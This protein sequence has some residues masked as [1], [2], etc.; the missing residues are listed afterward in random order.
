[1]PDYKVISLIG[2]RPQF[3]KAA[4]LSRVLKSKVE[5][6]IVHTGQHY[7]KNMSENFFTDLNIPEPAFNLEVGS[8]SH[9]VQTARIMTE[10][11]IVVKKIR[12]SAVI[13]F[14]DTNSTVAGGLVSAKLHIPLVHVEAGL[15]SW[16]RE[17]PEEHNR[18]VTDHL[19]DLC[20]APSRTAIKN[21]KKEGLKKRSVWSGDIMF[22]ALLYNRERALESNYSLPDEPYHLLTLH[23]PS[24]VDDPNIL[25]RILDAVASLNRKIVFPV[26]PRTAKVIQDAQLKLDESI[27]DLR[28]PAGYLGL[29]K[30]LN[31]AEKVLTDSG[32][33][34]KEAFY[35]KKRT[36]VLREQTEW[37]EIISSGWSRLAGNDPE[38]IKIFGGEKNFP[39]RNIFAPYGNGKSA[40]IIYQEI[41]RRFL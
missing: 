1:M 21:L 2:A 30:L 41:K 20:L 8:G 27:F 26:H 40:E 37:Q 15:R 12:P 5:E 3:M 6:I 14:G 34:Q 17:M 23:R 38:K 4:P 39:V 7:D 10:F 25:Q 29:I 9:A 32:G 28:E 24:N 33:L 35:M 22:D 11:E 36:V 19:S 31:G 13:V 16:N 18:I